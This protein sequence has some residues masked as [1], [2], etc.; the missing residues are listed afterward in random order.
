MTS[1][2]EAKR[3]AVERGGVRVL[4]AVDCELRTGELLAVIGPNGAGKSTFLGAMAG[5]LPLAEGEV[6]LDG[7]ALARH[8]S[9]EL[10]KK[11]AVLPQ[12]SS[13]DFPLTVEEVIT[14]GRTPHGTPLAT[15]RT[16]TAHLLKMLALEPLATR[17]YPRCSGGEQ[18]RTQLGRVL[19]QL[20][21]LGDEA[22]FL[23]LDEP[24]ASLD[25][26]RALELLEIARKLTERGV[27]VMAILHDPNLV[28]GMADRVLVLERGKMAALGAPREV[29]TKELFADVFDLHVERLEHENLDYPVFVPLKGTT[30]MD[31]EHR[32]FF[33][34]TTREERK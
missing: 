13:L 5:D 3:V 31:F 21:P 4:D 28:S 15:D 1:R 17:P 33:T 20:M 32:L 19:A 26:A 11:R 14:L 24:T 12:Q 2:M 25:P 8:S 23:L 7:V 18:R 6:L 27:G 9:S 22:K 34:P 10:A 30:P 29:L 16:I